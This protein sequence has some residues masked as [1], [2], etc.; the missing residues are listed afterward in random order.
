MG[1]ASNKPHS[2][3]SEVNVSGFGRECVPESCTN[4]THIVRA[5]GTYW[6]ENQSLPETAGQVAAI[7]L[8]VVIYCFG[9][10]ELEPMPVFDDQSVMNARVAVV[11]TVMIHDT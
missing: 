4:P 5:D 2:G 6:T 8:N 3:D 11:T 7:N 10:I 1:V 9:H